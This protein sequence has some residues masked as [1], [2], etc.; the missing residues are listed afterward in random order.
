MSPRRSICAA[1]PGVATL[2]S[3][4]AC[5]GTLAVIAALGALG[6]AIALDERL[7]AGTI[8]ALAALAVGGL[9]IGF[10]RHRQLWPLL[11]GG[12]GAA[13]VG[14]AMSVQYVRLVEL[15]GFALLCV[16]AVWDWR[17]RRVREPRSAT[18]K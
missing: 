17:L 10:F 8:V 12:L 9:A 15:A 14:F 3:L 1:L 4:I 7:W 6:I 18:A 13:A 5:Y 11:I 2:L 16:A